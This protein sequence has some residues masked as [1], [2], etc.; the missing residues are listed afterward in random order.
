MHL[1][2]ATH[3]VANL[4]EC[5]LYSIQ[6]YLINPGLIK[7]IKAVLDRDKTLHTAKD[8]IIC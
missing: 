5:R 4:F 2:V 8:V 7:W 1:I 3:Q 6:S